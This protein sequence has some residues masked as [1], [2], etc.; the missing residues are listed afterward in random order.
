MN[1][2]TRGAVD[3]TEPDEDIREGP[4]AFLEKRA[5]VFSGR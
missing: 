1:G 4:R 5:P 2:E 3:A